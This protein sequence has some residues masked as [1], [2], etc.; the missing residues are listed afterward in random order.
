MQRGTRARACTSFVPIDQARSTSVTAEDTKANKQDS[1]N[2]SSH[3]SI[4][5]AQSVTAGRTA[6]ACASPLVPCEP[7]FV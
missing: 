1:K 6:C 4:Q 5:S 7:G 3:C 2:K